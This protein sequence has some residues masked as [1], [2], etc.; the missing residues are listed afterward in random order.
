MKKGGVLTDDSIE[1]IW[2]IALHDAQIVLQTA[3]D[4][5]K[6]ALVLARDSAAHR[7]PIVEWLVDYKVEQCK[8]SALQ[9]TIRAARL[10]TP[11]LVKGLQYDI[12][13]CCVQLRFHKSRLNDALRQ[14]TPIVKVRLLETALER[15][16]SMPLIWTG[17]VRSG[18]YKLRWRLNKLVEPLR[19]PEAYEETRMRLVEKW[20]ARLVEL[21]RI[22][23]PQPT[24]VEL[25]MRA[26][27]R[28]FNLSRPAE[29]RERVR[30]EREG[31]LQL[32]RARSWLLTTWELQTSLAM[33]AIGGRV[34]NSAS[35]HF[36][37]LWLVAR[38]LFI[39]ATCLSANICG[40]AVQRCARK[41]VVWR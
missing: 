26:R 13:R 38:R 9:T 15:P 32:R 17:L 21:H 20:L 4:D 6:A 10:A 23:N 35:L 18:V 2:E 25:F 16:R 39:V 1:R 41:A 24:A 34:A 8:L 30:A 27:Q 3:Q 37:G 11:W 22:A 31:K 33:W 40:N 7:L 29:G 28:Y 5:P 36:F 14:L 12:S 19:S